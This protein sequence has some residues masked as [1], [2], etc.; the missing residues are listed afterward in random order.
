MFFFLTN[1][2]VLSTETINS[3]RLP[4]NR[5]VG[6]LLSISLTC[7]VLIA[8]LLSL[9]F[10]GFRLSTPVF[11]Y[12]PILRSTTTVDD[13][14]PLPVPETS[15]HQ[16]FVQATVP[17]VRTVVLDAHGLI[18]EIWSNT[19]GNVYHYTLYVRS[20]SV[21]GPLLDYSPMVHSQY[22]VLIPL[23]DWRP[24][25]RVYPEPERSEGHV[26]FVAPIARSHVRD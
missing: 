1:V 18:R 17:P 14:R 22:A 19:A 5:H 21:D 11:P 24:S 16:V 23:V 4:R 25:G 26:A 10:F 12:E 20:G 15:Y 2:F 6:I 7:W 13:T 9:R 3:G 8:I